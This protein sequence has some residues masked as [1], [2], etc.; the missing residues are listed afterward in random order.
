MTADG[1]RIM[2]N[3]D[4]LQNAVDNVLDSVTN[5]VPE[6]I[7]RENLEIGQVPKGYTLTVNSNKPD[8]MSDTG[9][10]SPA[11]ADE[12]VTLT[13]TVSQGGR[14]ATKEVP[15]I[16]RKAGFAGAAVLSGTDSAVAGQEFELT[17]GLT[18]V[19]GE[20]FAQDITFVYDADMLELI[21]RPLH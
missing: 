2:Y 16:V 17:Y 20:V 1:E 8:I 15:V 9:V 4:M 11:Q 19:S 6:R 12:E 5:E 10:V 3:D 18:D 7:R 14:T 13:F 21:A